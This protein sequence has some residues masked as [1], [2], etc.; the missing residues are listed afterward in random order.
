MQNSQIKKF[1]CSN[2]QMCNEAEILLKPQKNTSNKLFKLND[3]FSRKKKSLSQLSHE[4]HHKFFQTYKKKSDK[5]P[6]NGINH[7]ERLE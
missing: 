1:T 3:I 7:K 5:F 6:H 4:I 2:Q